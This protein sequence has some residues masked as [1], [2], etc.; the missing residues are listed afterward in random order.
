[1]HIYYSYLCNFVNLKFELLI[2]LYCIDLAGRINA[3]TPRRAR[4][5]ARPCD[6]YNSISR[7]VH[8]KGREKDLR[9]LKIAATKSKHDFN[10][11]S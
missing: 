2:R 10:T 1:M 9:N 6:P 8:T 7:M 5:G 11:T 3:Q 4:L